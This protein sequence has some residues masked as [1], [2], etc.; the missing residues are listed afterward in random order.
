MERN[1]KFKGSLLTLVGRNLKLNSPAPDFR[2]VSADL[3]EA[4]LSDFP[5]G[6]SGKIKLINSFPSLDTPV[7]DM[8]VKEFNKRAT[9]LSG[10]IT[11]IGISKDLPFAQ[12]RFCEVNAI[13]NVTTFSD[14]KYSSFGVNYGLLIKEL[15]LLAR[16]VMVVDKSNI[17]RYTQIAPEITSPLD[18]ESALKALEVVVSNPKVK[19]ED[20]L[21]S[22]CKPCEAGAGGLTKTEIDKL[23]AQY[24]NWQLVEDKKIVKEFKFKDFIEAKYFLDLVS[25]I[26]EEQGHHPNLTLIYN[27]LKITLT[28]HAVGGLSENDFIMAKIIDE[29]Q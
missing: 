7:C 6:D 22:H 11:V 8:Q 12:M 26:S 19:T 10:E 17:L 14:Y 1:T 21:P 24:R 18:Y 23:I 9:S 5:T 28:T 29:L 16:S 4:R 13:K 27:K 20:K 3:K 25:I 15:N 2:V